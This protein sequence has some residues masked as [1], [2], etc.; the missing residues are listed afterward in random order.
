MKKLIVLAAFGFLT[1]SAA[2]FAQ[3]LKEKDVPASVK[4]A[5]LKKYPDAKKVSW[6][7]E[8]GNF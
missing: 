7:K 4:A 5:L 1:S 8:K 2:L 6:E 3:D